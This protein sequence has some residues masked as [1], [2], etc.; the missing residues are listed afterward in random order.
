MAFVSSNLDQCSFCSGICNEEFHHVLVPSRPKRKLKTVLQKLNSSTS[1]LSSYPTCDK[2]YQEFITVHNIPESCFQLLPIVKPTDYIKMEPEL[3]I[4]DHDLPDKWENTFK[5]DSIVDFEPIEQDAELQIKRENGEVF[6]ISEMDKDNM[7]LVPDAG[8]NTLRTKRVLRSASQKKVHTASVHHKCNEGFAD[9]EKLF[10]CDKCEKTFS[11]KH[12]LNAHFRS[13]KGP[14]SCPHCSKA[15]EELGVLRKHLQSHSDERP[16]SCPRC[17]KAF[18]RDATLKEHI[19]THMG[20]KPFKCEEC[21]K[22]F[23]LLC[24]L[25]LHFFTHTGER[26]FSCPHCPKT[27]SHPTTLQRHIRVHTGE[28]PYRC[29]HCPKA[30]KDSTALQQHIRTHTGERPFSCP[31]CPMTYKHSISL[32]Q[33]IKRHTDR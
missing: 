14:H 33:H 30:L 2:C 1:Q 10:E 24:K 7:Q 4:D 25:K 28:R 5:R 17:P 21:E 16:Y 15:F 31:H 27:F 6:F 9:E 12:K 29:P 26:P 22:T 11:S 18:K 23:G 8:T 13:H 3:M 20:K 32:K 19:R